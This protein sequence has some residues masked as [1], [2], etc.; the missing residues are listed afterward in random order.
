MNFTRPQITQGPWIPAGC[1]TLN[2]PV[3]GSPV[4]TQVVEAQGWGRIL[5]VYDYSNEGP[6]NFDAVLAIPAILSALES[7]YLR[8]CEEVHNHAAARKR[9]R[10]QIWHSE[11]R[12]RE[13]LE[14]I[15]DSYRAALE[16]AGYSFTT[17][18]TA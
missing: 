15:R 3:T 7:A 10:K 13:I 14:G 11:E 6:A 8:A 12:K 2:D 5:E 9:M 1:G 16:S 17:E 4:T 18:P